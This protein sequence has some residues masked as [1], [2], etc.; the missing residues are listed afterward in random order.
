MRVAAALLIVVAAVAVGA[1]VVAQ[2]VLAGPPARPPLP[3]P[4]AAVS[5]HWP[6]AIQLP[7]AL[8]ACLR[9]APGGATIA[10]NDAAQGGAALLI[11]L[12]PAGKTG[13]AG[14]ADADL[15]I[16]E[17]PALASLPGTVS[18]V[19]A[20]RL[21]FA[22]SLASTGSGAPRLTLQWRCREQMCRLGGTLSGAAGEDALLQLA[23]SFQPARS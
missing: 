4:V 5:N 19:S 8:P 15:L 21:E 13:C 22:R 11:R 3:A 14:W 9:Y 10:P 17:A 16:E 7:Q 20:N 2:V 1:V 12:A 18:T 23:A 6:Y